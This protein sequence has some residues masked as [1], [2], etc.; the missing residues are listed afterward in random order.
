MKYDA[1][2]YTYH[3]NQAI[4]LIGGSFVTIRILWSAQQIPM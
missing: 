3:Y 4:M 1:I 2:I